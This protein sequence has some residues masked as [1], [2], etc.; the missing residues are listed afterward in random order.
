MGLLFFNEITSNTISACDAFRFEGESRDGD[1]HKS[2]TAAADEIAL[3]V[4]AD[5]ATIAL[6]CFGFGTDAF[7]NCRIWTHCKNLY[8]YI[9][10][11]HTTQCDIIFCRTVTPT[12]RHVDLILV[13]TVT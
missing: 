3:L 10:V 2:I 6:T 1:E 5:E 4:V 9:K 8:K 12:Y 13:E 7:C 11:V